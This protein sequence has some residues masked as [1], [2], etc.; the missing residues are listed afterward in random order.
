MISGEGLWSGPL[1][2]CK[3]D[4]IRMYITDLM[5]G[6]WK[7]PLICHKDMLIM[8]NDLLMLS[9]RGLWRGFLICHKDDTDYTVYYDDI[10]DT[11]H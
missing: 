5:Q 11:V 6:L 3:D 9:G 1:I 2:C 10:D 7:G 4:V 8:I